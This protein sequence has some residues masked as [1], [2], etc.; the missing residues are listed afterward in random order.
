VS[1]GSQSDVFRKCED[2]GQEGVSCW[3]GGCGGL[4]A[5]FSVS[6]S[7]VAC[8]TFRHWRER[9]AGVACAWVCWCWGEHS[10]VCACVYLVFGG[11]I[12]GIGSVGVW[13]RL[14]SY[15]RV[16]GAVGGGVPIFVCVRAWASLGLGRMLHARLGCCVV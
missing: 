7:A 9:Q 10:G 5:G 3:S 6:H 12:G 11:F 8:A 1:L 4:A 16:G 15:R 13:R 14:W 2:A